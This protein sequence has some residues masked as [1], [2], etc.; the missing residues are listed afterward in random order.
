MNI[1]EILKKPAAE[2]TA[3]EFDAIAKHRKE[4]ARTEEEK[5]RKTYEADKD[6]FITDIVSAFQE[7]AEKLKGIKERAIGKGNELRERLYR[8]NGKEPK[9]QKSFQLKDRE[10]KYKVVIE[11]QE[12]FEFTEEAQV[13]INAIKELFR[14][15]FAG[16]NKAFFGLFERIL[17][18]NSNG[19]YDAKLL[20]KARA[21]VRKIGDDD[22]QA[23]FDKLQDC[24]RVVGSQTYCRVYIK[25]EQK[26]WQDVS[27]NFSAL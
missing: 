11:S 16:R 4:T 18:R 12:R 25:N 26:K 27:L 19:D 20:A 13:H 22:L 8:M 24:L 3:E 6:E 10:D 23:E 17:M 7:Q 9:D 5:A 15:K 1:E 21:E 14:E 2:L